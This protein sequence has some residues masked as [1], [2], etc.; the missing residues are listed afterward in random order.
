MNDFP[1]ADIHE[2]L[3]PNLLHQLIKGCFKDHLVTWIVKYIED[4]NS[5]AQAKQIHDNIDH[6]WVT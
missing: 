3:S 5:D 1:Q 2:L 4:S 6:Q